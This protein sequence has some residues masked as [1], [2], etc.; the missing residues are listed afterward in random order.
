MLSY[1]IQRSKISAQVHTE[2]QRPAVGSFPIVASQTAKFL[3]VN[4]G[5]CFCE[6]N[7]YEFHFT[8]KF[9]NVRNCNENF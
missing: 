7:D 8:N 5:W 6:K 9:L 2:L 4:R 3:E 1:T